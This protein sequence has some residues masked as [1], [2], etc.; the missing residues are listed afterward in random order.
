MSAETSFGSSKGT[1][2]E[3]LQRGFIPLGRP[4][5]RS[6][7]IH[8]PST[9]GETMVF[10]MISSIKKGIHGLASAWFTKAQ[11]SKGDT[12]SKGDHSHGF[13]GFWEDLSDWFERA[14]HHRHPR[15]LHFLNVSID[16]CH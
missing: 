16:G 5:E 10:T 4:R 8:C 2:S 12:V 3:M 9:E 15:M 1:A 11:E 14:Q 7:W 6:Y 13:L